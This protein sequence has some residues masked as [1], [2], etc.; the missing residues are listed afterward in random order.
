[1]PSFDLEYELIDKGYY[2]IAGVDEV[3]RGCL[4]Y[5]VTAAAVIVPLEAVDE[6]SKVVKDSKKLT[7]KKREV[8]ADIIHNLCSVSIHSVPNTLI[9]RINILEAT[10]LA[11]FNAVKKLGKVDYTLIDGNMVFSD[12]PTPYR[13]IVKGD[14]VSLSIACASIVA[15]VHRDNNI[16][17]IAE[18]YPIYGF[19]KHKGYG[20]KQHKEAIIKHGPC[21]VHRKTF[22]GVREYV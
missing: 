9:D 8:V 6:L 18:K 19:D 1:M 12:F 14:S 11:M 10:K 21:P 5:D 22:K 4:A 2:Y 13:S 16:V 15:K 7:P 17:S 20:T 3:G